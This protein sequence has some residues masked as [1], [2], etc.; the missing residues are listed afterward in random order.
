VPTTVCVPDLMNMRLSDLSVYPV[1]FALDWIAISTTGLS[2]K[3]HKVS[4]IK[5]QKLFIHSINSILITFIN[6]D[7][8]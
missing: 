1:S 7:N 5:E 3:H 6:L 2:S 8:N 4:N